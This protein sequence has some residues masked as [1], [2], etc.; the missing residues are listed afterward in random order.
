MPIILLD[1]ETTDLDNA[2][3]VQL[4]Y[5]NLATGVVLNDYFL[6]PVP[7]SFGSMA[8]HHITNEMVAGKPAFIGSAQQ[9]TLLDLAPS[10]IVVA[11]NAPFDLMVLKNEGVTF[12]QFI[13]TLRVSR[14][15]LKSE[16]YSLQYLR[17]SLHLDAAGA[18][19]DAL[20]D[21]LVLEALFNHLKQVVGEKFGLTTDDEVVAQMLVLTKT[22]VLLDTVGFGKYRGKSFEEVAKVDG[23]YLEW[24]YGSESQKPEVDQNAELVF[25]LKHY[26][27]KV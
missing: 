26:L 12:G 22:P 20:G 27:G 3:M 13:D 16:Q 14:H 9:A 7:I 25:T 2:R 8:V 23:G 6:P 5:K 10:V 19:H 24:L 11:H 15:L 4:A 21:V 1:T 17:Y 18:A